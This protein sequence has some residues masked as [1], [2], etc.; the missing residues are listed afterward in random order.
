M[1]LYLGQYIGETLISHFE[2]DFVYMV[3]M[4]RHVHLKRIA[5]CFS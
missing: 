2:N 5:R 3:L 4:A 1:I